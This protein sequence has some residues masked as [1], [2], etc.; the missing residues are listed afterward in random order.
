MRSVWHD[1]YFRLGQCVP[2][3]EILSEGG[4]VIKGIHVDLQDWY[5]T[6]IMTTPDGKKHLAFSNSWIYT[7]VYTNDF[8]ETLPSTDRQD[9]IDVLYK[10]IVRCLSK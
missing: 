9:V 7:P 10:R 1:E 8:G 6:T 5:V 2:D 3:K 4:V